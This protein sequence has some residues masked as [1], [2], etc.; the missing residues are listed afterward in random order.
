MNLFFVYLTLA[1]AFVAQLSCNSIDSIEFIDSKFNTLDDKLKENSEL[2]DFE[3]L[4]QELHKL[5]DTEVKDERS[6]VLSDAA[7][8]V[9]S[10]LLPYL[11]KSVPDC[12]EK[13][14]KDLKK[15]VELVVELDELV[16]T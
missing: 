16:S 8:E 2:A 14:F 5:K 15:N 3:Q 4:K 1:F 7:K 13:E 6:E 10:I 12:D 9:P 11:Q